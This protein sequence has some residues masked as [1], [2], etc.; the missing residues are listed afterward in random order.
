MLTSVC[1]PQ[2]RATRAR[3]L[4]L[5]ADMPRFHGASRVGGHQFPSESRRPSRDQSWSGFGDFGDLLTRP[6]FARGDEYGIGAAT[7]RPHFFEV[8]AAAL[9]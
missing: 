7:F 8:A 4:I 5:L 3:C 9:R 6:S 2:T 1:S